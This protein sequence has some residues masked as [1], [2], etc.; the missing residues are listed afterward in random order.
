[1]TGIGLSR[2]KP[3]KLGAVLAVATLA[4]GWAQYSA[5]SLPTSTFRSRC[6]G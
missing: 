3:G 4:V 1:M 2:L 6:L 5:R